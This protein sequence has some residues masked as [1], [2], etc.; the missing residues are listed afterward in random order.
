M[1]WPTRTPGE[2]GKGTRVAAA[3][4]EMTSRVSGGV[5]A[6]VGATS[7][8]RR[9][10][11]AAI[12]AVSDR[13]T[14]RTDMMGLAE[15]GGLLSKVTQHNGFGEDQLGRRCAAELQL[16]AC[17]LG[18]ISRSRATRSARPLFRR[19]RTRMGFVNCVRS[20]PES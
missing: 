8:V 7:K 4:G 2:S 1:T 11:V 20:V 15:R 3:G 18:I 6:A 5:C 14:R 9:A 13:L 16:V 17:R 10:A 12:D 19:K